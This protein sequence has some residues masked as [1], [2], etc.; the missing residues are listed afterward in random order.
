MNTQ[1]FAEFETDKIIRNRYFGDFGYKGVIVEVGG[2]TPDF[3]SMS[4]HFKLNGW[5]TIIVEPIPEFAQKHREFGN[6]VYEYAAS[7]VNR[8][9]VPFNK[10]NWVN[11]ENNPITFESFSALSVSQTHLQREG[12]QNGVSDLLNHNHP[13]NV[14]CNRKPIL[15]EIKV[16]VRRLDY[17]FSEA[18]IDNI[19]I[20]SIDVEGHEL[21]VIDGINFRS[22]KPKVIVIENFGRSEK[23]VNHM[24]SVGYKLDFEVEYNQIYIPS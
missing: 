22:H 16:Q 19:D 14:N 23:Y 1:Y 3:I 18:K 4:R 8:N 5:R 2:A 15:T 9:D 13:I 10:I 7:C 21:E 17:I 12:Y 11:Q 24:K 6:E 20:L